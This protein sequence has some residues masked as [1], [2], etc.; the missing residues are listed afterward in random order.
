MLVGYAGH[1]YP[2]KGVDVF[3]QALAKA[4]GVRGLIVG[5][6][7]AE[8][9][10]GRVRGL[11][12]DLDLT[13]RVE[14]TGLVAPGEVVQ[15]LSQAD[16]LVLPNTAS[17]I[18]ER[19][20]SPLKLFEYLTLGRP[21]VASDLPAIREILEDGR[22][23]LLVAPGDAAALAAAF[24]RLAADASLAGRLGASA[25]ALAPSYT[26]EARAARLEPALAAA[27]GA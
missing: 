13:S 5:G 11:V 17:A 3:V 7:P 21:I 20:T 1:L 22:T 10:L 4:P 6:H 27:A 2:W 26:W 23:A 15:R 8:A 25:L 9:D 16:I 18:S 19:Y 14:I 24:E 12:R